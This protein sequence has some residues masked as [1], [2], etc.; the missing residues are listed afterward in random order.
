MAKSIINSMATQSEFEEAR[1][2]DVYARRK[3]HVPKDRYSWFNP[4]NLL[5]EQELERCLLASL[6]KFNHSPLNNKQILDVGCGSGHVLRNLIRWGA[7]PENVFGVDLIEDRIATARRLLPNSV[8]L[9]TGN[10]TGLDF[11]DQTF[12]LIFQCTMFSSILDDEVRQRVA[13]EMWRLLRQG[14]CV[15]W[16]DFHVNNPMNPDVRGLKKAEIRRLFPSCEIHFR[17]LTLLPP[18]ARLL[19]QVSPALCMWLSSMRVF[20][21]HYLVFMVKNSTA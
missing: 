2:R 7:R 1:I 10:A 6:A 20:S 16:Y 21:T 18:A 8:S 14:G 19:G 11:P 12:D 17:R 15:V 3:E 4:G 5:N 13:K 9:A